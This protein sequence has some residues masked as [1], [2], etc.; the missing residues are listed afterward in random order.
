MAVT[1]ENTQFQDQAF[2]VGELW[3]DGVQLTGED[4]KKLLNAKAEKSDD[5]PKARAKKS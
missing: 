5:E 3:V 4:L 2:K 1:G